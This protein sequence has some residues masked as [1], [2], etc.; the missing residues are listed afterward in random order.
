MRQ[1]KLSSSLRRGGKGVKR[2]NAGGG[3]GVGNIL[4]TVLKKRNCIARTAPRLLCTL[5]PGVDTK[6]KF[7]PEPSL[8][9]QGF[10]QWY[11]ALKAVARLPTGIPKEW[12][13]RE[14]NTGPSQ[15]IS[16]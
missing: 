15:K 3:G 4:S 10:Q 16:I 11:D 2:Q 13:R 5:E 6:L 12:R 14:R 1:E 8:G 9:Q 7:T